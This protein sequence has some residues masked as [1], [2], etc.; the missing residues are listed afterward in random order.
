MSENSAR[1]AKSFA[2]RR[3]LGAERY[4]R[5]KPRADQTDFARAVVIRF[6]GFD[7]R[8]SRAWG[9]LTFPRLPGNLKPRGTEIPASRSDVIGQVPS[10]VDVM[11]ALDNVSRRM[12]SLAQSLG[13]LGYF[14]D[15]DGP[16]AA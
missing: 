11:A 12:E 14:D 4:V 9:P 15:D 2:L 8:S 16:R 6:P 5:R 1:R 13:C 10:T 3:L 7:D